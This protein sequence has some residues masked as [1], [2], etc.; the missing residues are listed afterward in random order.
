MRSQGENSQPVKRTILSGPASVART[1]VSAAS[2]LISTLF[3][4]CDPVSKPGVGLN[5][6]RDMEARVRHVLAPVQLR[7]IWVTG[8]A[9]GADLLVRGPTPRSSLY[10]MAHDYFRPAGKPTEAKRSAIQ[11]EDR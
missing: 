2:R 10:G 3:R 5:A 4:T 8:S 7:D 11:S 9:Y 6:G 1:L